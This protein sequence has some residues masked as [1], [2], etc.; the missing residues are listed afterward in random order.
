MS[1]GPFGAAEASRHFCQPGGARPIDPVTQTTT[2]DTVAGLEPVHGEHG[3]PFDE[4][5]ARSFA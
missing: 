3:R 4:V 2:D 5:I 1:N